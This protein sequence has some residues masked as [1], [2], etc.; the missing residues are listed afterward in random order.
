MKS[1][2]KLLCLFFWFQLFVILYTSDAQSVSENETEFHSP[3]YS[4]QIGEEITYVVKY[5]FFNL[6]EI[7]FRITKSDIENNSNIIR[8]I[9]YMDSYEDLP[10][11][12]LHQV[13]YSYIDPDFF[14]VKFFGLMLEKDTNFVKYVFE[15]DS[16]IK[17]TKG[18]YNTGHIKFDSTVIVNKKCQDGLSI[19]FLAR[20]YAGSD[21]TQKIPCFV[22]EKEETTVIN[23]YPESEPVEIE[24]IDYEVDCVRIDGETD[25][26]SVYGLTGHFEG[27]FSNDSQSVPILAKM[28]V[29]LGSVTLELKH[30][31][32][33]DW[34][35]PKY[36]N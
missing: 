16:L 31:K 2:L 19:M 4:F 36:L 30:W 20:K 15:N 12:D 29:I 13:Y 10:F 11:V 1:K 9:A 24:Y 33:K 27:W 26:E 8:T 23:Y 5:A 28:N 21:T 17:I 7:K 34:N 35:P 25:F 32:K 3:E 14:P 22:N 6:G 18:N